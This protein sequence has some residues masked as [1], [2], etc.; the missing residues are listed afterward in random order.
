[1]IGGLRSV[2]FVKHVERWMSKDS[3]Y[4]RSTEPGI[5]KDTLAHEK[6]MSQLDIAFLL[7][8]HI[9]KFLFTKLVNAFLQVY[10]IDLQ[11]TRD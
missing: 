2:L 5:N 4:A 7:Y 9:H 1:M 3:R 10:S 6:K 11:T 8:L